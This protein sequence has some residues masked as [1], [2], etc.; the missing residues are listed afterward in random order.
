M[1]TLAFKPAVAYGDVTTVPAYFAPD[2]LLCAHK[3]LLPNLGTWKRGDGWKVS[4]VATG[5]AVH[6][7]PLKTQA[8]AIKLRNALSKLGDAWDFEGSPSG[9]LYGQCRAI[10][11]A[12][13][14]IS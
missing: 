10:L 13:G 3:T 8:E 11:K 2:G 6:S 9:V 1:K 7:Q 4:H 14:I 12:E 5:L